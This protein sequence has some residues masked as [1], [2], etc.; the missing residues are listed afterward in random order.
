MLSCES[1]ERERVAIEGMGD[2]VAP[3]YLLGDIRDGF[4]HVEE[5]VVKVG[6]ADG[7]S[8]NAVDGDRGCPLAGFVGLVVSIDLGYTHVV[9]VVTAWPHAPRTREQSV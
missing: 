4:H 5:D 7:R 3:A 2:V 8:R 6:T 9:S 1:R